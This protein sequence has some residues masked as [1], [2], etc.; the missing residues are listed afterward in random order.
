MNFC[1]INELSPTDSA[2]SLAEKI[3]KA[4]Y[5]YLDDEAV[6]LYEKDL[7]KFKQIA[8]DEMMRTED[9]VRSRR[10]GWRQLGVYDG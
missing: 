5:K 8:L 1:A 3:A 2:D 4:I 10:G 6:D 7:P 9:M